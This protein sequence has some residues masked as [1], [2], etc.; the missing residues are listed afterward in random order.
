[1]NFSDLPARLRFPHLEYNEDWRP[2]KKPY[3]HPGY[4]LKICKACAQLFIVGNEQANIREVCGHKE[5]TLC[6]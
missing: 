3:Q 4:T 1:M 6:P 2:G 5:C